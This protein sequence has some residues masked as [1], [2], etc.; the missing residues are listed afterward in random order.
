[1]KERG[2]AT[3]V[4]GRNV[5]VLIGL[6]EGCA[7]C[8]SHNECSI[9][10]KELEAESEPGSRIS[11]GDEVELDI[12]DAASAAGALWLLAV[13][14]ALFFGCYLGVGA[15]WPGLSEGAQ[16]LGGL[17]GLAVGLAFAATVARRGR[18]SRRPRVFSAGVAA[19]GPREPQ[20]SA[21]PLE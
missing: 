17:A 2:I 12:S 11:V 16:A 3:K 6:G 8:G 9:A 15:L 14:L 19:P 1:M 5:T 13:P 7:H 21:E 18:M 4:D 20:S 10:G